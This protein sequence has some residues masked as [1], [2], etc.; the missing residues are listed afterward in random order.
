MFSILFLTSLSA[1]SAYLFG[2]PGETAYCQVAQ[3]Y[4]RRPDSGVKAAIIADVREAENWW[5]SHRPLVPCVPA[6]RGLD[7]LA[8]IALQAAPAAESRD[9]VYRQAR[10]SPRSRKDDPA[11]FVLV[12]PPDARACGVFQDNRSLA[13]EWALKSSA[14]FYPGR[15]ELPAK[16]GTFNADL[17]AEVLFGPDMTPAVP[18]AGGVFTCTVSTQGTRTFYTYDYSQTFT[19]GGKPLQINL[20][21]LN[22][23]REKDGREL[24]QI[25][26]DE[27]FLCYQ[28]YMTGLWGSPAMPDAF[29]RYASGTYALLPLFRIDVAA[30]SGEHAALLVRHE[31]PMAGSGPANLVRAELALG[32]AARTVEGYWEL[33]Y[34]ADHHNWNERFWVFLDPPEGAA[35]VVELTQGTPWADPPVP[36]GFKLLGADFK[37]ITTFQVASWDKQRVVDPDNPEFR[38]GDVNGDTETDIADPV[39]LLE[40][41][42]HHGPELA[43]ADAADANDDGRLDLSDA[44]RLVL[45]L[46]HTDQV[47]WQ[48]PWPGD[49]RCGLDPTNDA[50]PACTRP[51]R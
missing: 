14:A 13:Q 29:L 6:E 2:L 16:A 24:S 51:C 38:R 11:P 26:V 9:I 35:H 37:P 20:Q 22:F 3:E 43:C 28:M 18:R 32:G 36:A 31:P 17:F 50:L 39:A 1:G 19:A 21:Y 45:R 7:S 33:V 12:A 15:I 4:D 47:R 5:A 46:F 27:L 34:S 8:R 23:W 40:R 44:I 42:F 30:K 48:L 10:P 25:V 49:W 41:L